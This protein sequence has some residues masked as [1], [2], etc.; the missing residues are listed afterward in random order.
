MNTLVQKLHNVVLLI[1]GNGEKH[2]CLR[3]MITKMNLQKKIILMGHRSDYLNIILCGDVFVNCSHWEGVSIALM[4][5]ISLGKPVVVSNINGNRELVIDDR[6]GII[7]QNGDVTAFATALE[8]I[9]L[10]DKLR[11]RFSAGSLFLAQE[12]ADCRSM[13]TDTQEL[14]RSM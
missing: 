9:L 5:A 6:N 2:D 1:V 10:D 14:Y 3:E 4:E 13:V 7:V 12:K 11:E 8:T